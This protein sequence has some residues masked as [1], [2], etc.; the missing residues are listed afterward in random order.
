MF[1]ELNTS[2]PEVHAIPLLHEIPATYDISRIRHLSYGGNKLFRR[3]FLLAED[4][5]GTLQ[6]FLQGISTID[7][8]VVPEAEYLMLCT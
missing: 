7:T 8:S 6:H 4:Y 2:I 3:K 5:S 1:K